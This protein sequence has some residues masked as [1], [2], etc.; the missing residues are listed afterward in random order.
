[1]DEAE[2]WK[3]SEQ[4]RLKTA[5]FTGCGNIT[6]KN[7]AVALASILRLLADEL[8]P[9]HTGNPKSNEFMRLVKEA[10]RYNPDN[11]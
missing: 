2:R 9:D 10:I 7:D 5:L 6:S 11:L 3:C 1:M 8:D 4:Q